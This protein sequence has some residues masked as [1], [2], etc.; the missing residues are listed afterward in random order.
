MRR[1]WLLGAQQAAAAVATA[2]AVTTRRASVS[3][4]RGRLAG[5]FVNYGIWILFLRISKIPRSY[6]ETIKGLHLM[7]NY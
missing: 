2:V 4:S 7:R 3:G 5:N 6:Q 1:S